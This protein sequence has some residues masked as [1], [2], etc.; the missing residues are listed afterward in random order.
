MILRQMAS[1]G[2]KRRGVTPVLPRRA[3]ASERPND[4][5]R[6]RTMG[7]KGIQI[8]AAG[9][10]RSVVAGVGAAEPREPGNLGSI[11]TRLWLPGPQ[12]RC[13]EL[14]RYAAPARAE[15]AGPA[16]ARQLSRPRAGRGSCP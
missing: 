4:L 1:D 15:Q 2:V 8:Y 7:Q 12:V 3:A 9:I 13:S 16:H 6:S 10:V 14:L 5:R 11:V